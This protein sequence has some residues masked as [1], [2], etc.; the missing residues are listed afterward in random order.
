[1]GFEVLEATSLNIRFSRMWG[2]V[3]A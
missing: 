1:M 3:S 2:C